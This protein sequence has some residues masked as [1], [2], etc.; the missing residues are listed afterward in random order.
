MWVKT[1][2]IQLYFHWAFLILF[3]K[4]KPFLSQV[5]HYM[6]DE[7]LQEE[8]YNMFFSSQ[9]NGIIPISI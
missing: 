4:I 1:V 3:I 7:A 2:L 6:L 8:N 5:Q 9:T